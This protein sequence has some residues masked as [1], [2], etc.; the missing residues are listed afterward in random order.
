[1]NKKGKLISINTVLAVIYS[2]IIQLILIK[3]IHSDFIVTGVVYPHLP[4][5][6]IWTLLFMIPGYLALYVSNK[7]SSKPLIKYPLTVLIL[8][9]ITF[10]ILKFL[11]IEYCFGVLGSMCDG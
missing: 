11:W 8:V 4:D 6:L 5:G 10:L 2:I 7:I 9:G 3:Q 1:M